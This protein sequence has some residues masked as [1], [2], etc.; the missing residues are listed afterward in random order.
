MHIIANK[1]Y[2][3]LKF[4][5]E[6]SEIEPPTL[7]KNKTK[8]K[9][10]LKRNNGAVGLIYI[11]FTIYILVYSKLRDYGDQNIEIADKV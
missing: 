3:L 6:K 1:N 4:T 9:S 2:F 5:S 7:R 10:D 8:K 11:Y